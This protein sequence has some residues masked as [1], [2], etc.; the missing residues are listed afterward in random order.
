MRA[1]RAVLF[2]SKGVPIKALVFAPGVAGSAHLR[3]DPEEPW[4][5]CSLRVRLR[6]LGVCGTDRELLAGL[7]GWAPE[8]EKE[9]V[10]GHE[11]LAEVTR[12]PENSGFMPGDLV[13][14]IVRHPDPVPCGN[15]GVGE[16]DMCRNGLYTE[17]GIKQ[18][19]G[20]AREVF[21]L[22]PEFAVKVPP[23][24]GDA[25]VLV[26][27]ASV[28]AK[29]WE[30]IEN[31]GRRA[32]FEP[33]IAVVTGAGPVG[34]LAALMARQ[35]GLEVHV[36]DR[37]TDGPKP[38][39]VAALGA[40]YCHD[41]AELEPLKNKID[42]VLECTGA[43]SVV[44][45]MMEYAGP[46][47]VVCLAGVSSGGR[48]ISF[49]MGALNRSLVLENEV[50]FGSVNANRRHYE[51]AVTALGL[52]DIGWLGSLITRRVPLSRWSEAFAPAGD[53]GGQIKTV[54]VPG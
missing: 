46:G 32:R 43:A 12:A 42:V 16:W 2:I 47:S 22:E 40:R 34:L 30:H 21:D 54:L 29:A 8:G 48:E 33:R 10:L 3:E 17:H 4:N 28:V 49:D 18:R 15:C 20:F 14:G 45:R 31:I 6:A 1:A 52:A 24:L 11:S 44:L 53:H 38:R 37:V 19:D 13:A 50:V 5:G 27:P 51:K 23:A 25:G 7:Y 41:P 35:R 36:L 26:E 39:A 9:M